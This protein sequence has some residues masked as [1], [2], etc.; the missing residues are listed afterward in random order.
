MH[1]SIVIKIDSN[2]TLLS[3]VVVKLENLSAA[4]VQWRM[5]IRREYPQRQDLLDYVP[6]PSSIDI[7]KIGNDGAIASDTC[8]AALKSR[9]ILAGVVKDAGGVV[10]EIDCVHH[11]RNIWIKA[12]AKEVSSFLSVFLGD[13]LQE[14]ASIFRVSPDLL[15][16]IRAYHKEFSLCCNYP[17]GHGDE[18]LVWM[19]ENYPQEFLM[20]AERA[21]GT[22]Q[23]V[24]CMGAG[25][26][27]KNRNLNLEFLDERLR[28]CG[29]NNILQQNLFII[30][31]SVEMIAVSRLFA[32]LHVSICM[33][34][35]WL[36]GNTHKLAHRNWGA[37]SIGRV[38]D[39]LYDTLN[40]LLGDIR[41]IHH[42][43][44]MMNIF[45]ELRKE[46][47]EFEG[48]LK[49][50]FE[51]KKNEYVV[52]SMTKAVPLKM[53]VDELFMPRDSDNQESTAML[54]NIGAKAISVIMTELLDETKATYKYLSIS[55]S[56]YS[57]NYCPDH[58][59]K[60]MLGKMV[61]NDPAESSFAGVTAQIQSYGRIDLCNAAAV[62]DITRNKFLSR[63][64]TKKEIKNGS[65]GFFHTLPE[66][67]QA[68]AVMVAME[69]VPATKEYNNE[70][71]SLQRKR[72]HE[73]E[74]FA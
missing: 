67:L 10:H 45:S 53:L 49:Y 72:R 17:K 2:F 30:L 7:A 61:T 22:R 16:V 13:S 74:Q 52:K 44:T 46:L 43:S 21:T 56:I 48:Y 51:T 34:V 25:P 26:I 1:S 36:A 71:L 69:N 20:H 33:P 14:I 5:V 70:A 73:K 47:P 40:R 28:V 60:A 63:P 38:F 42:K 68:T 29:C 41:L 27:Y 39:I 12:A 3:V 32:I 31:S 35:R 62:S 59:K 4:L 24:I 65:I 19:I 55:K 11:L 64:T 18:F 37:R 15:Q 66:E 6:M 57:W 9:R 54:E 58:V 50:E 8:N 23:D